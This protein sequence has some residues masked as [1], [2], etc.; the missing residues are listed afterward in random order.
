[1]G[2]SSTRSNRTNN[3]RGH[4]H[5]RYTPDYRYD[6]RSTMLRAAH[7]SR[8]AFSACFLESIEFSSKIAPLDSYS[9]KS[10]RAIRNGLALISRVVTLAM[11][12]RSDGN[13]FQTEQSVVNR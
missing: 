13:N 10:S 9:K 12:N 11:E 5:K 4:C 6:S 3:H 8:I 2:D 1:M 7:V